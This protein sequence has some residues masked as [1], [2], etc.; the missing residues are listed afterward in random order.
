[1][2]GF[3]FITLHQ[4]EYQ[5][6]GLWL[7]EVFDPRH[8][9]DANLAESDSLVSNQQLIHQVIALIHLEG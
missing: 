2:V 4:L 3:S 7:A 8:E 6:E 1:M 9:P 5:M